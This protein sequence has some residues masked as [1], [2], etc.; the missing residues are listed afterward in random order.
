MKPKKTFSELI[1]TG[2]ELPWWLTAEMNPVNDNFNHRVVSLPEH[3]QWLP[4]QLSG[5]EMRVL[6]YLPGATPRLT[7]QLRLNPEFS[8][9]QLGDNPD[10]EMLIQRGELESDAGVYPEGLY[11]RLPV[12]GDKQLQ[13]LTLH[14]TKDPAITR[15]RISSGVSGKDLTIVE[16]EPA[17][18]YLAAGQMLTSDSEQRRLDTRDETHWLPGP[19]PGTEVLPLHGHGTGN[20]MLIR[21]SATAAFRPGLDPMGDEVLVLSGMLQDANGRYP[22]GS[23][24]RNPVETW[25]SWGANAGTVVYYK[26]GHFPVSDNNP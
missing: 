25:Q 11:L 6:E 4:T 7:A 20:V 2:L 21:W 18:L 12:T 26:N 15:N 13:N 16:P 24:I 17:L 19:T 14:C 22:A 9:A 8:P 1:K 23:W 10:L 3:A 5:I